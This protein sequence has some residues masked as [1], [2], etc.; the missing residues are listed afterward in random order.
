MV[1][2]TRERTEEALER[3]RLALVT[4]DPDLMTKLYDWA[5]EDDEMTEAE[6][7]RIED[8]TAGVVY[9]FEPIDAEERDR[10]LA[11]MLAN[12]TGTIRE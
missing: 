5:K 9:D 4:H 7:K 8:P 6:M 11:E 10:V 3:F 1:A 2:E 12:P